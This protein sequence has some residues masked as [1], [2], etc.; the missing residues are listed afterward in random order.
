MFSSL[1]ILC[2]HIQQLHTLTSCRF[3]LI[4]WITLNMTFFPP[5][6]V[7]GHIGLC[8]AKT[9][10]SKNSSAEI[11]SWTKP[12]GFSLMTSLPSSVRWV[13]L[14]HCGTSNSQ[15]CSVLADEVYHIRDGGWEKPPSEVVLRHCYLCD[16]KPPWFQGFGISASHLL[17]SLKTKTVGFF[18]VGAFR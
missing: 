18:I 5:Q 13:P 2:F 17:L 15:V 14:H 9:G 1:L 12:T 8:K 10:A 16:W 11:F 4:F 6:R 7:N 3:D